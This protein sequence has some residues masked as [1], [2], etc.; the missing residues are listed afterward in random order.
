MLRYGPNTPRVEAVL[1][2]AVDLGPHEARVLEDLWLNLP[3]SFPLRARGW[4]GFLRSMWAGIKTMSFD[5]DADRINRAERLDTYRGAALRI[6]QGVARRTARQQEVKRARDEAKRAV[7][8]ALKPYHWRLR[9]AEDA[10]AG[11][12]TAAVLAD[13]LD[14]I[15]AASL[16]D[17]WEAIAAPSQERPVRALAVGQ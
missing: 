9:A 6:A 10:A 15:S 2:R 4:K 7:R 14:P 3:E 8:Q 16:M 12:A 17:P 1:Q 13:L 11:A 5:G